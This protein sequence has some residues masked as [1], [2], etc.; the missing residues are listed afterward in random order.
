VLE[1]ESLSTHY[2][3]IQALRSVSVTIGQEEIVALVGANG[4][5]KTT[6]MRTISGVQAVTDG[7]IRWL[8]RDI[9]RTRAHRR[10]ALGI[11]QVPEGRLVFG[12][13]SVEDNLRLGAYTRSDRGIADD[14]ERVYA[15]FPVL[16]EFRRRPAGELS[17]GQQQM[18]AVGRALM[19]RPKLLLLD[20]PSLG[21]APL[22]VEQIFEAILRL[23]REGIPMFLV[24]QNAS[25]ALAIADRGYVME[26]G[27]IVLSGSGQQLLASDRVN[28]AYLGL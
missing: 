9:T 21:L 2:G 14:R 25:A 19:G 16:G 15:M 3:R 12:P 5:G 13:L 6:L 7:R 24:E 26:T 11:A 18:L 4:A 28:E 17:G 8:G 1:I 10:V 27:S 23:K 22:V 20:E